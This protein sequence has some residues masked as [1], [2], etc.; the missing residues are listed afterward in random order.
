[1]SRAVQPQIFAYREPPAEGSYKS[2]AF[3]AVCRHESPG[4]FSVLDLTSPT[5]T[6]FTTYSQFFQRIFI[7]NLFEDWQRSNWPESAELGEDSRVLS[8]LMLPYAEGVT[9]DA[10]V[11]WDILNYL[12]AEL[13]P[14]LAD[15]LRRRCHA[16]TNVVALFST[17]MSIPATPFR[18]YLADSM[19]IRTESTSTDIR[20]SPR[21]APGE[22]P[23][24]L[25]GF[26][27]ARQTLLKNGYY[28]TLLKVRPG[29]AQPR[30]DQ[31]N[32]G[33]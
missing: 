31:K 26:E 15:V 9:V 18:F 5:A 24:L 10:I 14:L 1:M 25:P 29:T 33:Q 20:P 32:T 8:E 6:T 28:E 30:S 7:E 19:E 21:I 3:S 16:E 13:L 17:L 12:P 4:G 2:L 11:C 27:I 22:L 23:R